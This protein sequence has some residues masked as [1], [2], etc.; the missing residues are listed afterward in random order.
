MIT[1]RF[2]AARRRR[3]RAQSI[4]AEIVEQS[5]LPTFYTAL[6]APD[7][8]DGRFEMLIL[9]VILLVR[10]LKREGEV[11]RFLGQSVV[12]L[13][14]ADMDGSLREMGVGDL[15]VGKRVK[16]MARAFFGRARAYDEAPCGRRCGGSRCGASAQPVR[17]RCGRTGCSYNHGGIRERPSRDLGDKFGRRP[18]RRKAPLPR[19]TRAVVTNQMAPL[20]C[21]SRQ[22]LGVSAVPLFQDFDPL[23]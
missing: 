1:A 8:I 14:F 10:R 21:R 16:A 3:A 23:Q 5:R 19:A 9:H 17:D 12:E 11:G 4:Y 22:G 13:M 15:G 2:T 18:S 20:A 6:R 7:S